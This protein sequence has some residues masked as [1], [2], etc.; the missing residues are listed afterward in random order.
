MIIILNATLMV[1]LLH[2][3]TPILAGWLV[4]LNHHVIGLHLTKLHVV[5]FG[6]VGVSVVDL[7]ILLLLLMIIHIHLVGLLSHLINT[8]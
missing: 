1:I 4:C 3:L 5:T 6:L 8:N 7:G 2:A